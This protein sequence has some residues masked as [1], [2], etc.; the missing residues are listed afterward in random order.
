[1]DGELY[2]YALAAA[3]DS[4]NDGIQHGEWADFIEECVKRYSDIPVREICETACGTGS[5][6][7]ELASR[8]YSVTASDISEEMLSA[9]EYKARSR[10]LPI[11]FV[12]QD[13]RHAKMYTKKD[14]VICLLDSMN[15]LTKRD[16]IIMALKSAEE[17][18]KDGGL[19]IFDMN[20]KFKFENVYADNAYVLESEKV[21][22]SW[23]NLYNPKTKICNFYLSIF[24]ED[25]D[26]RYTRSDETQKEKMYTVKQMKKIFDETSFFLCGIFSDFSFTE[27]DENSDERLYYIL[28]KQGDGK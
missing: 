6:A 27:A 11:R 26:G 4:L 3:Y 28:K 8:G 19:F 22:C 14:L 13:M 25:D 20:S 18:L 16:D 5:M 10:D 15:Y 12:L 2:G 1:M 23:E 9:A 7:C 17:C 24:A 21:F